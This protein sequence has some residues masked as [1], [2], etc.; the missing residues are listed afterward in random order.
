[1][2][3]LSEATRLD[4]G[5][6]YA[7]GWFPGLP[8]KLFNWRSGVAQRS[9]KEGREAFD[10][11]QRS[12]NISDGGADRVC[13]CEHGRSK[14]MMFLRVRLVEESPRSRSRAG[15]F[16]GSRS[17]LGVLAELLRSTVAAR[18]EHRS[19]VLAGSG[20]KTRV[21]A[22][23]QYEDGAQGGCSRIPA[24]QRRGSSRRGTFVVWWMR[25]ECV[26]CDDVAIS[27]CLCSPC[28]RTLTPLWPFTREQLI[29][30]SSGRT[31]AL[32]DYWGRAYG[33]D[34]GLS[35]GR[36]PKGEESLA[37]LDP[38]VTRQHARVRSVGVG[39]WFVES[40][41]GAVALNGVA[42]VGRST[43]SPRDV[44]TV[45]P[46]RLLLVVP[47]PLNF[48]KC[49][50]NGRTPRS[51]ELRRFR[52]VTLPRRIRIVE[53]TGGNGGFAII[54][55]MTIE[56]P[57]VQLEL[58]RILAERMIAEAA[59]G[60]DVRGFVSAQELLKR[61]SFQSNSAT[62]NHVKQ[63]VR[64]VRMQFKL[65]GR[66]D[67]IESRHGLGYRLQPALGMMKGL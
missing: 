40:L 19:V 6:T 47:A 35:L 63:L 55:A 5:S 23:E 21:T 62:V 11:G 3:R 29:G 4:F 54:G 30:G 49:R 2:F 32:V 36:C 14:W 15:T 9:N 16:A 61:V 8:S 12:A 31:A 67:A 26:R 7:S 39:G 46:S 58:V 41:D 48:A 53:P 18:A 51:S 34:L 42:V 22:S 28:S 52:P 56:L 37:I 59:V 44:V 1:M 64:R 25:V 57:L 43:L 50:E 10:F 33:F 66:S 38:Q 20:I 27:G 17:R 24:S 45:G 60:A 65:A 13:T